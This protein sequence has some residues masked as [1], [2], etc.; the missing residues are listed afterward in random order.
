MKLQGI[1]TT[2]NFRTIVLVNVDNSSCNWAALGDFP[3]T[4]SGHF[5]EGIKNG[6]F[7][8]PSDFAKATGRPYKRVLE[9][10]HTF[11]KDTESPISRLA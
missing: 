10:I 11:K 8:V 4:I 5:Y 6:V 9:V 7:D 2:G 3:G 1:E